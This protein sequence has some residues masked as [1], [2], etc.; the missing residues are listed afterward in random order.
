MITTLS[1]GSDDDCSTKCDDLNS[2]D[3][4]KTTSLL[5]SLEKKYY[6]RSGMGEI[7]QIEKLRELRGREYPSLQDH[8]IGISSARQ[9]E[10]RRN[11]TY[12]N[13]C[14]GISST[15]AR[16]CALEVRLSR[17][18]VAKHFPFEDKVPKFLILLVT[19]TTA[20][21]SISL[22]FKLSN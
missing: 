4:R 6:K 1:L 12:R 16:Y 11:A 2:A 13:D 9:V 20:D 15:G 7:L 3:E 10:D 19:C 8:A 21:S 14:Y 18:D 5:S 22:L 17:S